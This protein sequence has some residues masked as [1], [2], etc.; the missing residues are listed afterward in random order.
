MSALKVD[1]E[2]FEL[3]KKSYDVKFNGSP[4]DL[5]KQL[6]HQFNNDT[7]GKTNLISDKTIRNFF[8]ASIPP[9]I[10]L[11][12]LNY[13]CIV[14]L[15]VESYQEA[16]EKYA[17]KNNPDLEEI[18][19]LYWAYLNE[20][21]GKMQIL[22]MTQPVDFNNIFTK[23]KVSKNIRK[24]RRFEEILEILNNI[25][26]NNDYLTQ[27]LDEQECINGLDA[28][29]IY[30]K[31]MVLGLPGSGKTTLSKHIAMHFRKD[32][33]G[34][35]LVPIYLEFKKI[36]Q[37][38]SS[39]NSSMLINAI[40]QEFTQY[41]NGYEKI[42][43]G[44]LEQGKC[45]IL[46]D[47]LDEVRKKDINLVRQGIDSLVKQYPKNRFVITCRIAANDYVFS[48]FRIV[49]IADFGKEQINRFVNNWFLNHKKPEQAEVFLNK[50]STNPYL[51]DLSKKPLLLTVLCMVFEKGFNL[52]K[53]RLTLYDN[54]VDIL[55][56]RWDSSRMIERDP[57]LSD[58]KITNEHNIEQSI[59]R[60]EIYREKFTT[61]RKKNLL[62]NI[63]YNAYAQDPPQRFWEK[64]EL[65][66]EIR[67]YIQ[68]FSGIDMENLNI[69]SQHILRAI[70]S[71]YGLIVEQARNK[72]AFSHLI[73][74]E[75]FLAQYILENRTDELLR[76]IVGKHLLNQQWREVF[77][78]I[79]G[80]LSNIDFLL[81][82]ML[83]RAKILVKSDALQEMLIWLN[84]ITTSSGVQSSSWRAFF[85]SVNLTIDI[86]LDHNNKIESHF[87]QQLAAN[88]RSL[89]KERRKI[90]PRT[91]QCQIILYLAIIITLA[92]DFASNSESNLGKANEYLSYNLDLSENIDIAEKLK[93][94]IKIA[95]ELQMT[96][97]KNKLINLEQ[98]LP[99]TIG[100][101]S[102]STWIE[103]ANNLREILT[104]DLD[105]GY[106][107][108][109]SE[110]D[111]MNL[112]NY[113]YVNNLVVECLRGDTYSSKD[114]REKEIDKLLL[115]SE[116]I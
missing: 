110:E 54:A 89:N 15:D 112:E 10:Q 87:A 11:K 44:F 40:I 92:F 105:I 111:C 71:N 13:L 38:E 46:L 75:Y 84:R 76:E 113:F 14:L 41:I 28:V 33:S 115:I 68:N 91:P 36:I 9:I 95:E 30:S 52:N 64:W 51:E 88:L 59:R 56:E 100:V 39:S 31:L 58:E 4:S 108:K 107:K 98:S 55:L 79:A 90:I 80:R 99:V 26:S 37:Y 3:L 78:I 62:A 65:E 70:E 47:G 72:Y 94:C 116:N 45:I 20:I 23:V 12:N 61:R 2:I 66:Q 50:L 67:T 49:E 19:Q 106:G 63:A 74:Q 69:D 85:L 29:K 86:Y 104:Q 103:W 81:K 22:D 73:F 5:I 24:Q 77:L 101:N 16:L 8:K 34:R 7:K 60:D 53:E 25:E 48:D 1:N 21:C 32:E 27:N 97:L 35:T 57:I 93:I 17:S 43:Q 102:V 96:N 18:L 82:L 109:L 42:V 114:L 6:N 83:E